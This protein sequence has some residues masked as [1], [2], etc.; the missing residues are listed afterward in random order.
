MVLVIIAASGVCA[1]GQELPFT[2]ADHGRTVEASLG[3]T[4]LLSLPETPSTGYIWALDRPEATPVTVLSSEFVQPD[5]ER[6]G[7]PGVR[8]LRLKPTQAGSLQLRL[9]R[10]R[11]WEGDPSVVER[12]ELTVQVKD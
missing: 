1:T 2:A 12:F 11:P 9:K 3:D 10:W 5:A 4:I 6:M 8:T 7:A